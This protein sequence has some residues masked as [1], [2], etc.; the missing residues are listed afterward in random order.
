MVDH[1]ECKQNSPNKSFLKVLFT[2]VV[3]R[4]LAIFVNK[5]RSLPVFLLLIDSLKDF[6]DF[7]SWTF[8][9]KKLTL[10]NLKAKSKIQLLKAQVSK[11]TWKNG[12]SLCKAKR[13]SEKQL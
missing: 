12:I 2:F 11:Q 1:Y 9:V 7:T 6:T 5:A 13:I 8:F 3:T 10:L 4:T